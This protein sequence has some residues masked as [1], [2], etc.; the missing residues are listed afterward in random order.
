[1]RSGVWWSPFLFRRKKLETRGR[2][3]QDG[4]AVLNGVLWVFRTGVPW[5]DMPKRYPPYQTCHRLGS[6]SG[7]KMERWCGCCGLWW[8]ICATGVRWMWRSFIEA[9]FAGTKKG[10]WSW[11]NEARQRDQ[12]H[13]NRRPPWSSCR[14]ARGQRWSAQKPVGRSHTGSTI[15]PRSAVQTD[16]GPRLLTVTP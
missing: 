11:C 10:R 6:S 14:S 1:M 7:K 2:P 13:G 5:H 4:R 9:T 3:L 16:R 8:R 15:P 12:D